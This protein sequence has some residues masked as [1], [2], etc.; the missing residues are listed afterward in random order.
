MSLLR[1]TRRATAPLVFASSLLA[2][3]AGAQTAQQVTVTATRVPTPVNQLAAEVTVI[4]RA[5]IERNEGRTLV[6]LLAQQAGLQFASNGGLGKTASLFIRGLESRHTLLLVDGVRVGSATVGTPSLDNLPLEAVERIEI[7]RGP[8]SSLYG[9][10][11]LGG[12][13]QVFTRQA[14]QGL[15]ANAK[16]SAGSNSYGQLAAGVGYG[17]RVFDVAVQ[18][19]HTDTR[20]ISATNPNVPF[21]S[22]NPDR[23]GFRQSGGSLR[24]GWRP[25]GDWRVELLGL[26]STGLTRIDDG[27]G[28][29][30]RAELL[31]EIVTL[32][33]RGSVLPGWKTRLSLSES[34]DAYDTLASA[35]AFASL[36]TIQTR[37]RQAS[38]ENTTATPLGTAL[39]L[40]E[41]TSEKV[42][43]P[44]APFSVSERDI[45]ALAL[46]LNGNAA[47][48]SWQASLRRDRNSQFG[49]IT[50]GALA[51]AYAL[52]P[53]WQLGASYGTSQT[54]PSFNQL[55]FP[56]FG[57]PTLQ[58][59][60]GKHAELSV[61]YSVGEHHLRAAW[62]DYRY[63]GFISSGPQPVNLPKVA[64]DGLSLSYEGRWRELDL[65]ASY[66]HTDP[67]NATVG[68]ANF[69]KQL[70]RRAKQALRL[71]VDWEGGPWSAGATLAAFSH[72][73]ENAANTT[74]LGG[75]GT[76]D[77]RGEWAFTPQAR[78]G[79]RVN[80]LGDKAYSTVLGYDQPGRQAFV[81]LRWVMR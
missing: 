6:E 27:P 53:A 43:R 55:Y 76:L 26:H 10:G 41:R 28:A 34:T 18:A 2:L 68:N 75:Y 24:L 13:V 61:R 11:A 9:N 60:E 35:S 30:A 49:G 51:Y 80:N 7:V 14:P 69:G 65:T 42:A 36:G 47:A 39:V 58:P 46:G 71:G 1:F 33:A 16:V 57:S 15:S 32:S 3:S 66:D 63:R 74:R 67:R 5:A 59:E 21:G 12:V 54:L 70:V 73:F 19:Q 37:T 48:H 23:D 79:L 22:Y 56:G 81:T 77:L 29:D 72:R 40:I 50:T 52:T 38:W 45:D 25:A 17:E 78:L 64:I 62:Y 4:D 8:M 31:N 20:G 44:G